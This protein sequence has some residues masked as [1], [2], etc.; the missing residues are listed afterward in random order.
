MKHGISFPS[1]GDEIDAAKSQ[2][3]RLDIPWFRLE[4]AD[5]QHDMPDSVPTGQRVR[6]RVDE[7]ATVKPSDTITG[8][9]YQFVVTRLKLSYVRSLEKTEQRT[10]R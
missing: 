10:M 6:M 3:G 8:M 4:G 7:I 9:F 1:V 5:L 2:T